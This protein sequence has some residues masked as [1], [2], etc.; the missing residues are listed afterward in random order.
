MTVQTRTGGAALRFLV[1]GAVNTV[2]TTALFVILMMHM[3]Y[4]VA[5]VLSF[6]TGIAVNALLL[7]RFVFRTPGTPRIRRRI[8]CWS[9]LMLSCGAALSALCEA[10]GLAPLATA[11][12]VAV[13][14]V[15]V[16]FCGSRLI[17]A[18]TRS[19]QPSSPNQAAPAAR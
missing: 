19:A 6:S 4:A 15:P 18:R 11:V 17:V 7:A 9:L 10:R 1:L 12:A 13:V 3:P 16:N 14:V 5:Y 2:L 8:V